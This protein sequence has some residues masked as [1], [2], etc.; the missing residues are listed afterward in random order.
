LGYL[1]YETLEELSFLYPSLHLLTKFHR[2]IQGM[3]AVLFLPGQQSHFMEGAFLS[4]SAPRIATSFFRKTQGS[5]EKG[6]NLSEALQGYLSP[7][8]GHQMTYH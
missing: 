1:C 2:D 5:L 6:F 4:T 3:G 7:F 8:I